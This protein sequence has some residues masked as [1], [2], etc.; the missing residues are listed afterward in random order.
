MGINLFF[1][2]WN[3]RIILW[4]DPHVMPVDVVLTPG[5]SLP[6]ITSGFAALK[7]VLPEGAFDQQ[8]KHWL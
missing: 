5:E 2:E 1:S 3:S 8:Q 6:V 7:E 4:N